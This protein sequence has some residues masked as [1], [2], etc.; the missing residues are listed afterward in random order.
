MTILALSL[1]LSLQLIT[2][3]SIFYLIC[4][5]VA[6]TYSERMK[7]IQEHIQNNDIVPYGTPESLE[8]VETREYTVTYMKH[9]EERRTSLRARNYLDAKYQAMINFD[10]DRASILS[11]V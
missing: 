8:K 4:V 5:L 3:V 11:V 6:R 9:G 2:I 7:R 10:V 1:A